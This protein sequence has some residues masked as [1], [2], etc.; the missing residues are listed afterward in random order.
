MVGAKGFDPL[1]P[2]P[3]IVIPEDVVRGLRQIA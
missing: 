3:R 2:T 1:K